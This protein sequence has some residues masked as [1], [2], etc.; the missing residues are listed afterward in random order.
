MEFP[1]EE[2]G[3]RIRHLRKSQGFTAD[4]I[5]KKAGVS[6]SMISQI[7]RGQVSPSLETLWKMSHCLKVP[8]FSFFEAN[9]QQD[10]TVTRKNEQVELE[11]IRPNVTYQVLSPSFGKQIS[12]F[13]LS[14]APGEVSDNP[15]VFHTG[16]EC[17]VVLIGSI[18]VEID[19]KFYDLDEG[20]SIYFDSH[21]PHR[22]VNKSLQTS[23]AIWAMTDPM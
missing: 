3:K 23:I 14:L 6:Q 8:I 15:L 12:L 9:N 17:G 7:E 4:D 13:K 19:N 5:A 16:E 20:D 2:V 18:Q 1:K 21:L 10:V 11:R 22:F